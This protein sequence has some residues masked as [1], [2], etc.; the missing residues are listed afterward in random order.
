M[1]YPVNVTTTTS[2]WGRV[3]FEGF[4]LL[5]TLKTQ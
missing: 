5:K 1:I 4:L 2:W 3:D